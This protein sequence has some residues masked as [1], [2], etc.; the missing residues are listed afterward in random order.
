MK[1]GIFVSGSGPILILT[2]YESLMDPR[3]LEK[4]SVKGIKKFIAFEVPVETLKAKYGEHFNVIMGDV[5]QQDDLRVLI[6]TDITFSAT[7]VSRNSEH[8]CST[9]LRQTASQ[10]LIQPL[11]QSPPFNAG[12][13]SLDNPAD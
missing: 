4:L 5:H 7:S 3:L 12:L 13:A 6:M 8:P 9:N 1:A 10:P 11:V 2:S